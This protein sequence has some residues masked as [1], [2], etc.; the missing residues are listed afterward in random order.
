[1][2]DLFFTKN[3]NN[4]KL[5]INSQLLIYRTSLFINRKTISQKTKFVLDILFNTRLFYL[6]P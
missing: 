6:S 5:K 2:F 4:Q 3:Q 1:M